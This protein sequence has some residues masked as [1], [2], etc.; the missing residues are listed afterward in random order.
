MLAWYDEL[1][2]LTDSPLAALSRDGD[3]ARA[4]TMLNISDA[5]DEERAQLRLARTLS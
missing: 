2:A 1:L 3:T 5:A 4:N